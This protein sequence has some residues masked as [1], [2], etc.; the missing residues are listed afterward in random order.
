MSEIRKWDYGGA[1]PAAPQRPAREKQRNRETDEPK[2]RYY[3]DR[4]ARL[5]VIPQPDELS[6]LIDKALNALSRGVYWDR[7]SIVNILL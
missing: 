6:R 5:N 2:S 7:G 4:R 3:P 1:I